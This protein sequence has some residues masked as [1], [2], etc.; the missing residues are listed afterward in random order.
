MVYK[1]LGAKVTGNNITLDQGRID[2]NLV[3]MTPTIIEQEIERCNQKISEDLPVEVY[4][5]KRSVVDEDPDISKLAM[6]LPKAIQEVRIVDIKEFDRQPDG[7]CHVHS[8][9]EIK[10][11]R[12]V[13]L[14]NK[15]KANRRL[16]FA[17]TE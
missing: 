9:S 10:G 15:G 4:T 17:L 6:Q 1:D 11:V 16:Y 14:K 5:L 12:L 7:G 3:E 2:F 8:L 13:K